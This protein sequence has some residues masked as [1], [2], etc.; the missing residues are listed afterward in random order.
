MINTNFFSTGVGWIYNPDNISYVEIL[1]PSNIRVHFNSGGSQA[2]SYGIAD[3][4][5]KDL[6][7]YVPKCDIR[8]LYQD[9]YI[10]LD[11]VPDIFRDN[12]DD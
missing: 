4:I 7:D 6:M 3:K 8:D 1:S 5:L 2:F 9:K 12:L 11:Q 10:N